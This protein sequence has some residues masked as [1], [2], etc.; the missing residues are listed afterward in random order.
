MALLSGK[1]LARAAKEGM[2]VTGQSN[3]L[4]VTAVMAEF[5]ENRELP[6][7]FPNDLPLRQSHFV[8]DVPL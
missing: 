2:H 6:A 4:N 7:E 1:Q 3:G 5:L 8:I